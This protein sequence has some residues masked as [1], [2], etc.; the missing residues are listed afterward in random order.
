MAV[1]SGQDA[2]V[3][4]LNNRRRNPGGYL[5]RG[6]S[7]CGA[8]RSAVQSEPSPAS[9]IYNRNSFSIDELQRA[10]LVPWRGWKSAGPFCPC[11]VPRREGVF[12]PRS[13]EPTRE[14]GDEEGCAIVKCKRGVT[15]DRH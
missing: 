6:I 5:R 1:D 2:S 3:A 15:N 14:D 13:E 11:E 8:R 12:Y 7:Q 4:L 9:G 10:V